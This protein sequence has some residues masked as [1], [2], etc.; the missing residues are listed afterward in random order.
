MHASS[1]IR[2]SRSTARRSCA[3][4]ATRSSV[5]SPTARGSATWSRAAT[6][7]P[8]VRAARDALLREYLA[9]HNQDHYQLLRIDRDASPQEI[10]RA[11]STRRE[12][13]RLDRFQGID[14]G[15]DH[16][17]LEALHHAF[18]EAWQVLSD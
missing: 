11:Y 3:C 9:I 1:S 10:A 13:F 6:G 5:S 18:E 12:D 8:A 16:A 17:R 2:A 14:L 15:R 7:S 4:S